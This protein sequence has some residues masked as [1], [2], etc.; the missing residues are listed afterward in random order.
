MHWQRRQRIIRPMSTP[1]DMSTIPAFPETADI[2]SSSD[3]YAQRFAGP[4]G[5]WML[6]VQEQGARRLLTHFGG[7]RSILDVGGG[8][9]QIAL[10]LGHDGHRVTVLG[11]APECA[12]RLQ[13]G[14]VD[15]TCVFVVGNMLDLPFPDQ[16]FDVVVSFRIL[17]HCRAWQQLIK[18]CCRVARQ[19]V[20]MDY[21]TSESVNRVAPWLFA[22]KKKYEQNTRA[23]HSFQHAEVR[24]TFA[25][26]GFRLST[27]YKQF[28]FPMVLHR[29][30]KC[31][32]LSAGMEA[33]ARRLGL[34]RR[35]GSPVIAAFER[36]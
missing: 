9:G 1:D 23:W 32:P 28:F 21:P 26:Q 10:P 13:S 11:S 16:S 4:S 7:A 20:V 12:R 19:G 6:A 14:L 27:Q 17:T 24:D 35:L 2:E 22:T 34:T 31:R 36:I 29:L 5:Q 3:D 18:E 15:G 8:H 25:L 33:T 30:L